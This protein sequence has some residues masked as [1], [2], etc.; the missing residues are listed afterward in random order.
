MP[1]DE[2]YTGS[3]EVR[4]GELADGRVFQEIEDIHGQITRKVA[5]VAALQLD[6]AVREKLISLGWMPPHL[7]KVHDSIRGVI[8]VT[9]VFPGDV[10][11]QDRDD[12]QMARTL[13][14]MEYNDDPTLAQK[15]REGTSS[16]GDVPR[17]IRA[18]MRI[19]SW[20]RQ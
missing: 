19:L 1:R 16:N 8:E 3:I 4:T 15:I 14:A 13:L 11:V 18:L 2:R 6:E 20:S 7:F 5:D 10:I 17:A 9:K 12:E